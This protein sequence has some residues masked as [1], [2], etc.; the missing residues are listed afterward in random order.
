MNMAEIRKEVKRMIAFSKSSGHIEMV[1][2]KKSMSEQFEKLYKN[3]TIIDFTN[4]FLSIANGYQINTCNYTTFHIAQ[5]HDLR[6][7]SCDDKKTAKEFFQWW[8]LN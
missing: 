5:T 2:Y 8:V 1:D 4:D 3:L 7:I 6:T